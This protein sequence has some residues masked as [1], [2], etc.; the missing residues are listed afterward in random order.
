MVS[1]L[2]LTKNLCLSLVDFLA[3][4]ATIKTLKDM[5]AEDKIPQAIL[6]E[7]LPT[8]TMS[9]SALT[10]CTHPHLSAN[11]KSSVATRV[12]VSLTLINCPILVIMPES[13]LHE[14]SRI[15]TSYPMTFM[16][17]NPEMGLKT[18]CGNLEFVA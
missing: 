13:A 12:S 17:S 4:T 5:M 2:N 16:I 8:L 9:S 7:V 11:Q 15:H 18:Y 3:E 6:A 1:H 14:L 10:K